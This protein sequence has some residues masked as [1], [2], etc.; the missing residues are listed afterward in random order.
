MSMKAAMVSVTWTELHMTLV[1]DGLVP[2]EYQAKCPKNL[3]AWINKIVEEIIAMP[4]ARF[5]GEGLVEQGMDAALLW[6]QCQDQFEIDPEADTD[7]RNS[8]DQGAVKDLRGIVTAVLSVA[9]FSESELQAIQCGV[10]AMVDRGRPELLALIE[11]IE[12][13]RS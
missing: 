7:W 4:P 13:M 10:Q 8:M 3:K 6:T 2:K 1:A 5:A 11:K 12:R 9:A